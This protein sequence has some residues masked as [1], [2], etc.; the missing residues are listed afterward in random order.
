[1]RPFRLNPTRFT[2]HGKLRTLCDQRG[3]NVRRFF[4]CCAKLSLIFAA[5]FCDFGLAATAAP[6]NLA[7]APTSFPAWMR[8]SRPGVTPAMM[9][10]LPSGCAEA[11]TT[12]PSPSFCL[13]LST[14]VRSWP[15]SRESARRVAL[16]EPF[17][18]T[19]RKAYRGAGGGL[20]A[21]SSSSRRRRFSSSSCAALGA[22]ASER[23]PLAAGA[24][25]EAS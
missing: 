18:S 19:A 8:L 3:E 22:K 20:H 5:G 6:T 13:R 10:T 12:T 4:E 17:T 15:R 9:A 21:H 24:I 2:A 1:M 7:T 16:D 11:R 23:L 14:S 25:C